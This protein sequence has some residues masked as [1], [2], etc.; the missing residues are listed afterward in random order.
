MAKR[1]T[2]EAEMLASEDLDWASAEP[3]EGNLFEWDASIAGPEGSPYEGGLFNLKL[4]FGA[5]Y[6]FTPPSVVFTTKVYH[7][8]VKKDSG[9]ICADIIKEAW[10]PSH[11]V[12]W[13]LTILQQL[14]AQPTTDSPLEPEIAQ[15]LQDDP[16]AFA[17][18]A[19]ELTEKYAC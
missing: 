11:N 8:S 18:K 10:K 2:K 5:E 15:Q 14:L 4:S 17:A 16:E 3:V 12:K 19:K 1:L 13:V 9:E 7:P 6:P